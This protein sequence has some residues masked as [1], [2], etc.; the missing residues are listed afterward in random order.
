MA[1]HS[2]FSKQPTLPDLISTETRPAPLPA[3]IGPYRIESLLSK[4]GMSYVYLGIHPQTS[5][6]IVIK[7]LSPKYQTHKEMVQRFLKEAAVISMTNHPNIVK[8]Y[9]QGVWEKGFYIAIEFI[10]GI[11]LRQ[12]IQQKSLSEKRALEIILQVAYALC[13]L[14]THGVI[15]RDI[16]P[17]NILITESGEVK[18]I[19]FG[20]AQVPG[21]DLAPQTAKRMMGTP[22]Y[23]SPEQKENPLHV[24]VA[25]DIYSLGMIAYELLLGRLSYGSVHLA[26]LSKELRPIIEK[27]LQPD[28]KLRYQDIVDFIT[29]ISH[30]LK[31]ENR[32]TSAPE[33]MTQLI[34]QTRQLL[35][36]KQPPSWSPADIGFAV[37]GG[38]TLTGLYVDWFK[39]PKNCFCF[40]MSEP[41]E[42]GVSA[43]LQSSIFRGMVRLAIEHGF[44]SGKTIAQILGDLN[45]TLTEDPA[46]KPCRTA[47]LVLSPDTNQLAF[48]SC[49]LSSL[50]HIADGQKQVRVL[51]TDNELLGAK[52]NSTVLEIVDN[53]NSG[54]TI[55]FHSFVDAQNPDSWLSEH[56]L[57]AP[58]PLA[59][60]ITH[61]LSTEQTSA[62]LCIQ[63]VY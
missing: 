17:E 44:R 28:P 24:T 45:L 12:F 52:K 39:L 29:D 11:S 37:H 14:H 38:A 62:V 22:M 46:C 5:Q 32:Q 55:V 60:Q 19:D 21:D 50:W 27:A 35:V 61:H 41:Q 48:V 6:P 51:T 47:A 63:R 31:T 18:V 30:Y 8:L 57:L 2:D 58:Q 9:G 3:K 20:I 43:L 1:A 16:K 56:L 23:M 59:A 36:P 4:G 34:E 40:F 7:V 33:E 49:G 26:L 13:H 10:Q 53:W 42:T 15:H 54:D 25:S